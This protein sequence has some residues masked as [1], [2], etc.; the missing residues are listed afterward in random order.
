MVMFGGSRLRAL[1][2][3]L[4]A[5]T[6]S[7]ALAGTAGA[8][9]GDGGGVVIEAQDACDPVTFGPIC[10]RTDNSGRRMTFEEAIARFHDKGSVGAWRFAP[11][12]VTVKA[13]EVVTVRMGR[14]GEGHTFANVD[15][16]FQTLG[17][18]PEVNDV[19]FGTTDVAPICGPVNPVFGVAQRVIDTAIP[20][21]NDPFPG[22]AVDTSTPGTHMFQ[23]LIHPWM[24]ATVTVE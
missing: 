10:N 2:A 16:G 23:C 18:I 1:F 5:A 17:C 8:S 6:A 14:G 12:H 24:H 3:V 9:S 4:A 13:G 11:D 7:L 21:P 19:L 20:G 22:P 15:A